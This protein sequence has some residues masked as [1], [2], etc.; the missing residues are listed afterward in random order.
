MTQGPTKS[1]TSDELTRIGR[2]EELQLASLHED[3]T[4]R[5]Y[6]T[7]WVGRAG[8][9]LYLRSAR[10]PANGWYGPA[11]VSSVVGRRRARSPS[12][13]FPGTER[14]RFPCPPFLR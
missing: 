8:V 2:A 13:C 3:A 14:K 5:Q 7:V 10:A 11:I 9:E 6:V 12:A 4:L 1:W